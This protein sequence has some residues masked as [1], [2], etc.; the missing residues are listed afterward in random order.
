MAVSKF[1]SQF[2]HEL[3]CDN[4]NDWRNRWAFVSKI[5]WCCFLSSHIC[6]STISSI[7]LWKILVKDDFILSFTCIVS[8]YAF[9][10]S[11]VFA[12][13]SIWAVTQA[14]DYFELSIKKNCWCRLTR[15]MCRRYYV[16]YSKLNPS[17]WWHGMFY[18]L[19][20]SMNNS[21]KISQCYTVRCAYKI[22]HIICV[23][24]Y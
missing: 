24:I 4:Q 9:L 23:I 5:F 10:P 7:W 6:I 15:S 20:F 16:T 8:S 22:I 17:W 1:D 14:Y 19:F 3:F 12:S 2:G 18:S 11:L 13:H 21:Y